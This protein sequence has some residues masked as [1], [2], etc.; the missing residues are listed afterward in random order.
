MHILSKNIVLTEYG[1]ELYPDGLNSASHGLTVITKRP[2]LHGGNNGCLAF[3]SFFA[4]YQFGLFLAHEAVYD[5]AFYFREFYYYDDFESIGSICFSP[6]SERLF[7][8]CEE[9]GEHNNL[10]KKFILSHHFHD[11]FSDDI[12][13][14]LQNGISTLVETINGFHIGFSSELIM[15]QFG[16]FLLWHAAYEKNFKSDWLEIYKTRVYFFNPEFHF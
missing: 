13:Q 5:D 10:P 3:P 9:I 2:N 16:I 8:G 1:N 6:N 14:N 11:M 12:L 7:I 4:L 15:Y